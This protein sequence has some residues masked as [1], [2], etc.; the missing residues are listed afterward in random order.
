MYD[1]AVYE[2]ECVYWKEVEDWEA[3]FE[4]EWPY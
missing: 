4:R 1:R 2:L 3:E